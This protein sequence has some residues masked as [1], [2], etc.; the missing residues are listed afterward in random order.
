M[1]ENKLREINLK[2]HYGKI[3]STGMTEAIYHSQCGRRSI[4]SS[5][6]MI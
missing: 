4:G 5:G 2:L 1:K 6:P 3:K